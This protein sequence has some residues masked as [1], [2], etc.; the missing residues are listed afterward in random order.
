MIVRENLVQADTPG[1]R[2]RRIVTHPESFSSSADSLNGLQPREVFDLQPG[3]VHPCQQP[4]YMAIADNPELMF[5]LEPGDLLTRSG[6]FVRLPD[7]RLG[8]QNKDGAVALSAQITIPEDT[9]A[10]QVSTSGT[11]SFSDAVG[12]LQP[13]GELKL[14]IVTELVD[15]H[16]ANGVF[17]TTSTDPSMV[18]M[19][20]RTPVVTSALESS[21]VDIEYEWKLADHYERL[22]RQ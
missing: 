15:F 18:P 11:V 20:D 4:F 7:G 8:I 16:S 3:K 10:I 14:A 2:R 9:G 6:T 5:Q 21:N 1:Y 13:A 12:E 22:S 19:A 17:F